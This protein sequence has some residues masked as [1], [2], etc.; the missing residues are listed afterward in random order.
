WMR[1]SFRPNR[2]AVV[3]ER[4]VPPLLQNLHHRLLDHSVQHR[5]DAQLAHPPVRLPDFHPP[6]R[7]RFIGST[8]QLFPDDQQ[9]LVI[10]EF[11]DCHSVDPRT[12][13]V[14]LDS[15]NGL[16]QVLP[17]TYLLRLSAWSASLASPTSGLLCPL[18]T[19]AILA[20]L[21]R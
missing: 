15:S 12:T 10:G 16:P 14:F 20:D 3:G 11:L 8:A 13:V 6:H 19:S 2:V 7:L 9:F 4:R 1:R 18:L 21:P 5:R 17:L